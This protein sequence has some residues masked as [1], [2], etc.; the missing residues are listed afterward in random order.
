VKKYLIIIVI[1]AAGVLV[2]FILNPAKFKMI[3]YLINNGYAAG[4]ENDYDNLGK[5]YI[6]SWYRAAKRG[7]NVFILND[8]KYDIRG[9]KKIS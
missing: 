9:G 1:I 5:D 2:Y 3:Q 6:E 8:V 4:I 7:D